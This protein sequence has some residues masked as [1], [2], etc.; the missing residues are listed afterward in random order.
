M[1]RVFAERIMAPWSLAGHHRPVRE[2]RKGAMSIN[3]IHVS[4][5]STDQLD[6]RRSN[7]MDSQITSRHS[8]IRAFLVAVAL[9]LASVFAAGPATAST[10]IPM[11]DTGGA[12]GGGGSAQV[13][14]DTAITSRGPVSAA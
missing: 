5:R 3:P 10:L 4:R 1:R 9:L 13:V 8:S 7:T 6:V 2:D 12:G 11:F 14:D